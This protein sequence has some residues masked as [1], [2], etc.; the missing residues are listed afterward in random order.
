MVALSF[1]LTSHKADAL[2]WFHQ[3][4]SYTRYFLRGGGGASKPNKGQ[5]GNSQEKYIAMLWG[6]SEARETTILHVQ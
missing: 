3:C 6:W 4:L 1:S 5:G 2:C